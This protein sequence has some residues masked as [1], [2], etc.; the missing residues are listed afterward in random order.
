MNY[1]LLKGS[2]CLQSVYF[3]GKCNVHNCS[4][5]VSGI[6]ALTNLFTNYYV[7]TLN[8]DL[9]MNLVT[10]YKVY[11]ALSIQLYSKRRVKCRFDY[12]KSNIDG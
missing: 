5:T 4:L 8:V 10:A 3:I 6:H 11:T 7:T 12:K 1:V 2:W 9:V